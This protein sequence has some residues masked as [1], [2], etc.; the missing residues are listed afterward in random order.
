MT[1]RD[2]L[3]LGRGMCPIETTLEVSHALLETPPRFS[4]AGVFPFVIERRL[5]GNVYIFFDGYIDLVLKAFD[6]GCML[7]LEDTEKDVLDAYI[8]WLD[9]ALVYEYPLEMLLS[10]DFRIKAAVTCISVPMEGD[11]AAEYVTEYT[12]CPL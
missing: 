3:L 10:L 7:E 6:T 12:G 11:C 9:T 1:Y 2:L 8:L 4:D 5:A